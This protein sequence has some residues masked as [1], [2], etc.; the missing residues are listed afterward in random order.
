M[1]NNM[2]M[3]NIEIH[4]IEDAHDLTLANEVGLDVYDDETCGNC[5]EEVG[6]TSAGKFVKFAILL[7]E[8]AE[9]IVCLDC[10]QP[11]L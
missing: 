9:W 10:A 11:V 5:R 2:T 6:S 4:T 3:R 7:D 1:I 8:E